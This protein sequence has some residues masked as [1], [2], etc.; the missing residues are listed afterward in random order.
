MFAPYMQVSY[1]AFGGANTASM[2]FPVMAMRNSFGESIHIMY[3]CG[4]TNEAVN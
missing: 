4:C 1:M 3:M 2:D